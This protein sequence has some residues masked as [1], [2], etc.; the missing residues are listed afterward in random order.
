MEINVALD[1]LLGLRGPINSLLRN[2]LWLLVFNAIYLGFFAFIPKLIGSAAFSSMLNNTVVDNAVSLIPVLRAQNETTISLRTALHKINQESDELQ[3]IFRFPDF[4]AVQLG[5]LFGATVLILI[6]LAWIAVL[7]IR[8]ILDDRR[9]SRAR[10]RPAARLQ[11]QQQQQQQRRGG[12][13]EAEANAGAG[14]EPLL[15]VP[16]LDWEMVPSAPT[17]LQLGRLWDL[18]SMQLCRS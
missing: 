8:R 13:N 14:G 2:L 6:R 4:A 1:E 17:P 10:S 3:T 16:M 9:S 12:E 18:S 7:K 5:Y 11:Q 15:V